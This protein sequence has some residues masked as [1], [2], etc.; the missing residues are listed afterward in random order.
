[1]KVRCGPFTVL[2]VLFLITWG[3][4]VLFFGVYDG[5]IA[6][7]GLFVVVSALMIVAGITDMIRSEIGSGRKE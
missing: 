3:V 5:T 7:V 6:T 2:T 1:M 4:A